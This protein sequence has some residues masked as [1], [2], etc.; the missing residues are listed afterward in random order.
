MGVPC[1]TITAEELVNCRKF[2]KLLLI[3][4]FVGEFEHVGQNLGYI[5]SS[6]PEIDKVKAIKELILLWYN[7]VELYKNEW[8]KDTQDR[9]YLQLVIILILLYFNCW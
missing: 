9:Y 6:I 2:N 7:E 8:V 3:P 4:S 1:C 5:N